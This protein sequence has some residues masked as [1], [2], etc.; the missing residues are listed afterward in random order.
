MVQ[1]Y[2]TRNKSIS[3]SS[4]VQSSPMRS[5][6]I[7]LAAAVLIGSILL[8]SIPRDVLAQVP[9]EI[10][11]GGESSGVRRTYWYSIAL[12][13]VLIWGLAPMRWVPVASLTLLLSTLFFTSGVFATS[14]NTDN[15]IF[16]ALF[17]S[18]YAASLFPLIRDIMSGGRS[19]VFRMKRAIRTYILMIIIWELCFLLAGAAADCVTVS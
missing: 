10:L 4:T 19:G 8:F 3:P 11:I 14:N 16:S 18:G 12:V 1:M 13:V 9:I 17:L 7:S 6:Y 5:C 2:F 15:L